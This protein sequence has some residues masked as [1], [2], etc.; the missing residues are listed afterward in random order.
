MN[1]LVPGLD[2][3]LFLISRRSEKVMSRLDKN[4]SS[5]ASMQR[6]ALR[7]SVSQKH[8][9]S[10]RRA[11]LPRRSKHAQLV[12]S[13]PRT[14]WVRSRQNRAGSCALPSSVCTWPNPKST[15]VEKISAEVPPIGMRAL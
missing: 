9:R 14:K 5:Y 12:L 13:Q 2:D 10:A 1:V 4:V 11:V 6:N 3:L 8:Y 7:F 15:Q